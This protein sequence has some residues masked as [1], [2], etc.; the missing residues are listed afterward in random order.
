M[1]VSCCYCCCVAA[2]ADAPTT[3]PPPPPLQMLPEDAFARRRQQLALG[4][5]GCV[6]G[7]ASVGAQYA[8][9]LNG[10]RI[11]L[12]ARIP[13]R[14]DGGGGHCG[15]GGQ[16]SSWMLVALAPADNTSRTSGG[17]G[18]RRP[19]NSGGA[20]VWEQQTAENAVW[21]ISMISGAGAPG[22]AGSSRRRAPVVLPKPVGSPGTVTYPSLL[23]PWFIG[24]YW[25]ETVLPSAQ[26]VLAD[27]L[28]LPGGGNTSSYGQIAPVL[29][30][31]TGQM[32]EKL[33][34]VRHRGGPSFVSAPS[35]DRYE[36][37]ITRVIPPRVCTP[38][39][40]SFIFD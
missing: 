21:G 5:V 17:G 36:C 38:L 27:R 7:V 12:G 16:P 1:L 14:G 22:A 39:H 9:L 25:R 35:S 24:T 2:A 18:G 26:D 30:R 8:T 6:P 32:G 3:A 10:S 19:Q 20:A 23:P 13:G 31:L 29:P 4:A 15:G 11:H 34:S 37:H 33:E 40:A 28:L